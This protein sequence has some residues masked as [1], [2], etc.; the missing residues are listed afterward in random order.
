MGH[1]PAFLRVKKSDTTAKWNTKI[2]PL[3]CLKKQQRQKTQQQTIIDNGSRA[4]PAPP[5]P[6]AAQT[7]CGRAE[8]AGAGSGAEGP[9]RA[10]RGSGAQVLWLPRRLRV[11]GG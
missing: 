6:S 8:L 1:S 11:K 4:P 3:F 5:R 7:S 10:Y 9:G 2:E